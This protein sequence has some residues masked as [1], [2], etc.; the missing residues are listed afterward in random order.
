MLFNYSFV[1]IHYAMH[2]RAACII[3]FF[4]GPDLGEGGLPSAWAEVICPVFLVAL[5]SLVLHLLDRQLELT[6]RSDFLW[7]SKL[8]S[9]EEGVETMRGINKILLE[10]I[11][12]GKL[13]TFAQSNLTLF[14]FGKKCQKSFKCQKSSY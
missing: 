5:T 3:S 14:T 10:N 4:S 12:P 6:S 9:E 2:F 11:L 1:I 13:K 8:S 7:R